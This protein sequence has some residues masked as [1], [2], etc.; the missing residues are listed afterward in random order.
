[1]KLIDAAK[2]VLKTPENQVWVS[3]PDIWNEL[4]GECADFQVVDNNPI[5]AYWLKREISTDTA[6]GMI[7]YFLHDHIVAV[8]NQPYR[9]SDVVYFWVSAEHAS[10][11]KRAIE[12]LLLNLTDNLYLIDPD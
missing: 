4:T 10:N 2:R 6:V 3:L 8:S 11:T 12:P 5:T 1:M 9:K 7:A